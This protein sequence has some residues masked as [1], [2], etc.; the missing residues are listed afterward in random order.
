MTRALVLTFVLAFAGLDLVAQDNPLDPPGGGGG[1]NSG[2]GGDNS[3]GGNPLQPPGEDPSNPLQP[4][5][6][7]KPKEVLRRGTKEEV[8][9]IEA[10]FKNKEKGAECKRLKLEAIAEAVAIDD[11]RMVKMLS[12]VSDPD[13]QKDKDILKAGEEAMKK[14]VAHL[15]GLYRNESEEDRIA[16]VELALSVEDPKMLRLFGRA[17]KDMSAKIQAIAKKGALAF[18][19]GLYKSKDYKTRMD[20]VMEAQEMFDDP[21]MA[22]IVDGAARDPHEKVS[23]LAI[24][25]LAAKKRPG[26]C[27]VLNSAAAQALGRKKVDLAISYIRGMGD[28]GDPAAVGMVCKFIKSIIKFDKADPV[29]V[30]INA[31]CF[32]ALG[33]LKF[34]DSP[35]KIMSYWVQ[36]IDASSKED[37]AAKTEEGKQVAA[38]YCNACAGG[39]SELCAN[40]P[41][42]DKTD[43]LGEGQYLK[44]IYDNWK[45]W[46]DANEKRL[47]L[48]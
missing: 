23:E 42:C 32:D 1:D 10:K 35:K 33:R 8:D 43:K 31:A 20:A 26:F 48:K 17:R 38:K 41:N 2:G 9:A 45:R 46:Y 5:V 22:K 7:E 40:L 3:G 6:Q 15:E 11:V 29:E 47:P 30:K 13:K 34:K 25:F 37:S 39:M 28:S 18:V 27:S 24:R 16:A 14:K 19:Q 12:I 44:D 4:P 21:A 36:V